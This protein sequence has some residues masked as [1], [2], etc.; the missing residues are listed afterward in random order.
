MGE[1]KITFDRFIRWMILIGIAFAGVWLLGRLS[2]VLLPFFVAWFLSYMLY[3]LVRF[4]QYRVHLRSRIVSIVVALLLVLSVLAGF[5]ALI[6]P[7]LIEEVMRMGSLLNVYFHDALVKTDLAGF[8][9]K[10]MAS[11][12]DGHTLANLAQQNKFVEFAQT[13]LLQTWSFL[14]GTVNL[15]LGV[16]G[17]LIVLMYMFF[18]LLDYEKIS[19]GWVRLIPQGSRHFATMLVQDVKNGMNAYF[20]GQALVA[21]CVGML[22]CIGFLIIDFPLAIGLG[23]FIG[24]LNMVPY[25]Q[26]I[27]F[28]PTIML[29]CLKA[30]ETG[31]NVWFI[32]L[33]AFV[34]FAVVQLIQDMYLTPR[35]MGH[36]TGLNPAVILLSLSV[37]GSLLGIT[38]FI[39]ALPLTTL[40][41]SYY[42]Q[43]ILKEDGTEGKK[44]SRMNKKRF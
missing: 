7:P 26:I 21:F 8:I 32:L 34:V 31:E 23:L 5:L 2:G 11:L 12:A 33:C 42:R 16:L 40:L 24:L 41:L 35:I 43:F 4:L 20:R 36:V 29:A 14:A 18:I 10:Q 38:G 15:A 1:E 44:R 17:T 28:I 9:E 22:F 13:L 25:M 6:L 30:A 19:T 37:W 3:P 39:I 27:G